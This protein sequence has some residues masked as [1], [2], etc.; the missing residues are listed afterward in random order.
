MRMATRM[1]IS[2][3]NELKRRM[4]AVTEPVS[5]SA[6]AAKA[7]GRHL[8]QINLRLAATPALPEELV[9][10]IVAA[11]EHSGRDW[12]RRLSNPEELRRLE[13]IR[14]PAG[15]WEFGKNGGFPAGEEFFFVIE[16]ESHGR[17]DFAADFWR[18]FLAPGVVPHP[19]FVHAF[20]SS[21]MTVW[22]ERKEGLC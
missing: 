5:W 8:D 6:I 4:L 17:A 9:E 15:A 7:F 21:A 18:L 10:S 12:A 22:D 11:G 14:G 3:C 1:N 19:F 20:A 13:E 16:P 2:L